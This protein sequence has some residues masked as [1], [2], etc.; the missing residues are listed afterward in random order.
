MNTELDNKIDQLKPGCSIVISSGYS[1]RC[2][3]ERSADD[4]ILRFVRI[5]NDGSWEVFLSKNFYS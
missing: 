4:K 5:K 2:E 3:A 1:G